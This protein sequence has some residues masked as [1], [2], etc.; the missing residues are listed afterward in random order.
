MRYY[1]NKTK[2]LPFIEK[3]V[4]AN[5][6]AE[7][8]SFVDLFAG[9]N[10]VGIHFKNL[11]FDVVSNDIM[12]YSYSI[13]RTYIELNQEPSFARL[14][15]LLHC[16]TLEQIIDSLNTISPQIH[17]FIY[18][19]Y[20]PH[21][22]RM[23]FTD[24]NALK[25]DTIR[26]FIHDWHQHNIISDNEYYYLLTS[27]LEAV[28]LISNVSGTYAAYLKT[29]DKRALK[30]IRLK[31]LNLVKGIQGTAY[32]Q[33]AN[34]LV[35]NISAD[36]LYLDPPY[37]S[38]Q[39][40]SNYFILELI[41]TGWFECEPIISGHCGMVDYQNL[42]SNYGMTIKAYQSLANLIENV[43]NIRTIVM[44]YNNEGILSKDEI[45]EILSKKGDVQVF[46]HTHKR[47]KSINQ[48]ERSPKQ[49]IEYLFKTTL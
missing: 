30:P 44:S 33:D 42:K 49:T 14:K 17:G 48:T 2:L 21:S 41:A 45:V 29:W 28:N 15:D 6:Y 9:T 46:Q 18:N 7:G 20:C 5:E 36:I 10:S 38:R 47:Y 26:T 1:G 37:N 3:V 25:I 24:E 22:G 11:G 32:K 12:E 31:P 35:A 4:N 34:T 23:Y 43:H 8:S 39:Y 16:D 27:L 40:H 13:A 19:H